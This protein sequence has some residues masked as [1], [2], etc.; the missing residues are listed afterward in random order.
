MTLNRSNMIG[1]RLNNEELE[2]FKQL[3]QVLGC[4]HTADTIRYCIKEV[5]NNEL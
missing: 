4:K 5:C 1:T 2:E 3:I